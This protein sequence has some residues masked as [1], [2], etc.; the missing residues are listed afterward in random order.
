[1]KPKKSPHTWWLP[2]QYYTDKKWSVVASV[3]QKIRL[4]GLHTPSRAKLENFTEL[5]DMNSFC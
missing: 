4:L 5:A 2:V 1:M 3:K